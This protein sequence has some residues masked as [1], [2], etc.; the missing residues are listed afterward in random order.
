[1]PDTFA[2]QPGD[3]FLTRI[4]GALGAAISVAQAVVV[5]DPSRYTHA[6][7]VLDN[8]QI[9]A[10]Q[11]AGARIDSLASL[12]SQ[13]P[14]AFLAVPQEAQDRRAAIVATARAFEG[15]PYGF[16][17]YLWMG[18]SRL[19]I[20]PQVL[21]NFIASDKTMICSALADRVWGL[22]GIRLFDDGRPLGEV[23]PGDLAHVGTVVNYNTGPYVDAVVP[24]TEQ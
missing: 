8:G 22:N 1:M 12:M 7:V 21:R 9:I 4:D 23:T 2:P 14:L 17:D 19:G 18:V 15:R 13:K 24:A 6:G 10:A 11:P 16:L 5:Q 20:R 3:I